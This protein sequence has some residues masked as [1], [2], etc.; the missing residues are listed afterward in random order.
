MLIW[1]II[2]WNFLDLSLTLLSRQYSS[3]EEFNPLAKYWLDKYGD[4]GLI[5]YKII[6]TLLII[7]IIKL[8]SLQENK[9]LKML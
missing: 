5:T 6:L 1:S 9:N 8:G 7:S 2:I 4:L 3:F